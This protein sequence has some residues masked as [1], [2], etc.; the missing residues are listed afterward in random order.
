MPEAF[1]KGSATLAPIFD[2]IFVPTAVAVSIS[3]CFAIS[4]GV[5]YPSGKPPR[6]TKSSYSLNFCWSSGFVIV[7]VL[8]LVFVWQSDKHHR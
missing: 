7:P 3:A 6:L 4:S 5:K 8:I 1:R 2:A